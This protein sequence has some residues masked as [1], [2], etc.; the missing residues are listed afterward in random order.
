MNRKQITEMQ[1]LPIHYYFDVNFNQVW[2]T[3]EQDLPVLKSTFVMLLQK[4]N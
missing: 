2:Q 1:D 4:K 3:G